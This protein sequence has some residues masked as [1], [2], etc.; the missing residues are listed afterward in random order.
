MKVNDLQHYP[1]FVFNCS[2]GKC[3]STADLDSLEF[4]RNSEQETKVN[5]FQTDAEIS[6]L[7]DS[8][9]NPIKYRITKI[10]VRDLRYDTDEKLY[11][12]YSD[13]CSHTY[14][15]E[16]FELMSIFIFLDLIG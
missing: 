8:N 4:F 3:F 12:I 11:G 15:K 7:W 2:D 1:R 14:G 10:D 13:D 9:P 6:I 16:K 5:S